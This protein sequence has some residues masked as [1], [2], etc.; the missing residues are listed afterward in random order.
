[1]HTVPH[2]MHLSVAVA[3]LYAAVAASQLTQNV[4]ESS[5]A[6]NIAFDLPDLTVTIETL[7]GEYQ[8]RA[9]KSV[10]NDATILDR[11]NSSRTSQ[12]SWVSVGQPRFH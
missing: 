12:L 11:H 9:Y 4:A 10:N 8:L 2:V 6:N 5:I 7:S 3:L 1:M